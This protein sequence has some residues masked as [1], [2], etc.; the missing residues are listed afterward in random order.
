MAS[1]VSN[2]RQILEEMNKGDEAL[3]LQI[4]QRKETFQAMSS[5]YKG[6]GLLEEKKLKMAEELLKLQLEEEEMERKLVAGTTFLNL[7][8]VDADRREALRVMLKSMVHVDEAMDKANK[9]QK[10]AAQSK[11]MFT[12]GTITAEQLKTILKDLDEWLVSLY[13]ATIEVLAKCQLQ[14]ALEKEILYNNPGTLFENAK[15]RTYERVETERANLAR[16]G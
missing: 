7:S 10:D 6:K 9:I 8:D 1:V 16:A 2:Q 15:K 14:K 13:G 4:N 12:G 5:V 11:G 3:A